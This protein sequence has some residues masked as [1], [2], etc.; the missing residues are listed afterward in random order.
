MDV[1]ACLTST[2][3]SLVFTA[4]AGMASLGVLGCCASP[5]TANAPINRGDVIAIKPA[6]AGD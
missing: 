5:T 1:F 3:K 4:A 6:E 2:S